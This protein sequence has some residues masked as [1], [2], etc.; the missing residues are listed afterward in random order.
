[1]SSTGRIIYDQREEET[2]K[3]FLLKTIQSGEMKK[4]VL[5]LLSILKINIFFG[6]STINKFKLRFL[7]S[8][9]IT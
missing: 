4:I 1:M 7:H 2:Q 5:Y 3:I 9:P 6:C 8:Q